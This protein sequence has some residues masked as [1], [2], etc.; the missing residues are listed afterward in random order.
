MLIPIVDNLEITIVL[1][2]NHALRIDA[3]RNYVAPRISDA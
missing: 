3:T 1:A 2:N